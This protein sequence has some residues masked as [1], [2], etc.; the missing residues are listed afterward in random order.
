MPFDE[1]LNSVINDPRCTVFPLDIFAILYLPSNLDI[2]DSLIVAT[3]L[4]C[5][6]FFSDAVTI[7]TKDEEIVR[8]GVVPTVW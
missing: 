8:S 7:L 3:A 6:D 4:Y 1:I 5:E 2:H